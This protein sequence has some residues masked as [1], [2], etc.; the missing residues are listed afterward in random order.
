MRKGNFVFVGGTQGMGKAAALAAARAGC[1]ILLVARNA[2][3]GEAAAAEMRA[4]G[5]SEA[6]FLKADLSTLAGMKAAADGI[7]GWK[8]H[9]HGILHSAMSAFSKKIVTSDGLELAFALQYLARAVINRLCADALAAS[10]DGRIVHLAGAVPYKMAPPVL[11]D[12][13]FERRKWGFFKAILVTHVEGFMFLE[14]AGRRWASRPVRLYASGVGSTR[15]QA[16]QDPSMPLIM[17]IMGRFGATPESSARNAIRLL[18]DDQPP[19]L[20]SAILKNPRKFVPE[21][22]DMPA[23]EAARLWDITTKVAAAHGI[24]LP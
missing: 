16:M 13:Q 6:I 4:A 3:A 7:F 19:A 22:L 14:E 2:A 21:P 5:A 18:L 20:Q 8:P 9:I 15:T 24:S 10:G 17:R 12:L 1:A 11:D 23:H